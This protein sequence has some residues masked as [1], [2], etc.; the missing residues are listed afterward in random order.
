[1]RCTVLHFTI[2][3]LVYGSFERANQ[4]L[5][6]SLTF[7]VIYEVRKKK[8]QSVTA[9]ISDVGMDFSNRIRSKSFL[10]QRELRAVCLQ[11]CQSVPFNPFRNPFNLSCSL[12]D[13][14]LYDT[15]LHFQIKSSIE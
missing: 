2:Y 9:E 11:G 7:A 3:V 13:S 1:M 8:C 10:W 14:S 4:F 6:L 12:Y 15:C 5:D